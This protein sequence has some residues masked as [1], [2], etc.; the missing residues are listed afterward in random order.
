[1]IPSIAPAY[2]YAALGLACVLAWALAGRLPAYRPVAL[3]LTSGLLSDLARR[4]LRVLILAPAR[5]AG[6]VPFTGGARLAAAGEVFS[7]L[8]WP[9]SIAAAAVVVYLGRRPWSVGAAWLIASSVVAAGY[10]TIRGELLGRC[11]LAVE[12]A[13]VLCAAVCFVRWY[14]SKGKT[15]P[16]QAS[17][18]LIIAVEAAS[19]VGAWRVGIFD[20][21][22][23]TQALNTLVFTVLSFMQGGFLWQ[24]RKSS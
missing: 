8:S 2:T 18:S 22:Q 13:A 20:N 4:A 24:T 3:L 17:L 6:H 10:P 9:A 23:L 14:V 1:V 11:Y 21:W 12:I 19:L 5:A 16:A 7:F 15:S